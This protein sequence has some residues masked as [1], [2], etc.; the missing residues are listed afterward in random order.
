MEVGG[1]EFGLEEEGIVA[2]V[3]VHGDHHAGRA[4]FFEH[5][6]QFGLFFGVEAEVGIDAEDEVVVSG[7]GGA[8]EEIGVSGDAGVFERV[9]VQPHVGD[10]KVGVGVEAFD[11][12]F[13][14]MEHVAFDVAANAIPGELVV[15]MDDVG[16]GAAFDGVEV[17]KGLV[18]DHPG[19]GEAVFGSGAVVE[20]AAVEVGVVFD[21]EN[22][23][24]EGE[25]CED[26]GAGAAGDRDDDFD[27]LGVEGGEVDG[28]QTTD[29]GADDGVE[30]GD[31]EVVDESELGIDDIASADGG[32]RG[33]VGFGGSGVDGGR[34]GGAV[35]AAEV[36]GAEDEVFVGVEDFSGADEEIPPAALAVFGPAV[37]G[38]GD[39]SG[40]A[41]GVLGAGKRVEEQ[42][43][44]VFR[45]VEGAVALESDAGVGEGVAGGQGE[46]FVWGADDASAGVKFYGLRGGGHGEGRAER[47]AGRGVGQF[48]SRK[49]GKPRLTVDLRRGE[50]HSGGPA[51]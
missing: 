15:G 51:D 28:E 49:E 19:E 43:G 10:A 45:G 17:D 12:F 24:E 33:A 6:G 8:L 40:D 48:E 18:G 44:V 3:G 46:R 20:I 38:I 7:L 34:A 11:E 23:F 9:E 2:F 14:L 42:D 29:G 30:L 22:L 39:G 32:E 31:A 27:A 36:I 4:G 47:T 25:A 41:G 37:A 35:A 5:G 26:G 1:V 13:A 50:R 21:G 16:A